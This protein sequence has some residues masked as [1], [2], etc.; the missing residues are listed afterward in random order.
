MSYKALLI[1]FIQFYYIINFVEANKSDHKWQF[2][3]KDMEGHEKSFQ[4][5]FQHSIRGICIYSG[6][7]PPFPQIK[8][9][10]KMWAVRSKIILR[11]RII[12]LCFT[13]IYTFYGKQDYFK[14]KANLQTA[15]LKRLL[16]I[17]S[18][19]SLDSSFSFKASSSTSPSH[20]QQLL[21]G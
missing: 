21:E 14:N 20:A 8:K 18:M 11:G 15:Q 17:S 1:I 4:T 7:P 9:R 12:Y 5:I 19:S 6:I 3:W 13:K 16:M 2:K 10:N